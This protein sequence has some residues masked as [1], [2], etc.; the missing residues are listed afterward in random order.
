MNRP[1]G[2]PGRRPIAEAP[3]PTRPDADSLPPIASAVPGHLKG[4]PSDVWQR[5]APVLAR[6]KLLRVTDR[7]AFFVYC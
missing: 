7:N 6:T 1:K 4:K 3:D 5:L 2:N